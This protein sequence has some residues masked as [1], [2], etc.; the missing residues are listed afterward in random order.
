MAYGWSGDEDERISKRFLWGA[1]TGVAY[2][3]EGASMPMAAGRPSGITSPICPGLPIRGSNGDVAADHYHRF[4]E[5]V[6]LMAEL[7]LKSYRFS[8][9][10]PRLLPKGRGGGERGRVA[11]YSALIDELLAAGIEPMITLY[12]WDLPLALQEELGAGKRGDRRGVCRL[13][14]PLLPAFWRPGETLV[15]LQRD[16]G[17]YRHGLHHRGP[18]T[19]GARYCP[20]AA[21]LPPCVCR[22]YS[23]GAGVPPVRH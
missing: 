23:G 6:A 15:H 20:G 14:P 3:V 10:W 17:V 2:Q 13:C 22:P 19:G 18:P 21:G 12:H 16:S 7:G 1:A 5:D 8:I 4:R 11:F 9:S